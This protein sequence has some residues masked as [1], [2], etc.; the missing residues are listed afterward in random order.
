VRYLTGHDGRPMRNPRPSIVA[1][2]Q[3]GLDGALRKAA[4][5][6]PGVAG[7]RERRL[8]PC[9]SAH[10]ALVNGPLLSALRSSGVRESIRRW[11]TICA[12]LIPPP[13]RAD[14]PMS[15][16]AWVCPFP[17]LP[18]RVNIPGV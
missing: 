3:V 10:N 1:A 15:P 13:G 6:L 14:I 9:M 18:A 8:V 16:P 17:H 2:G 5:E 7:A 11:P 12:G 4:E